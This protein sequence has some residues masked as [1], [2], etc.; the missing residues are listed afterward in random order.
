MRKH[1]PFLE[2]LRLLAFVALPCTAVAQGGAPMLTDDTGTPG[3]KHW[4]ITLACTN[5]QTHAGARHGEIP[6]LDISYGIGDRLEVGYSVAWLV[7]NEAGERSRAG[8]GDSLLGFKWHFFEDPAS[9]LAIAVTPQVEFRNM[10]SSERRGIVD[11]GTTLVLP[12]EI[13]GK[14]GSLEWNAEVGRSFPEI[15]EDAWLYGV[16][17]GRQINPRLELAVELHGTGRFAHKDD[18]LILN[19]GARWTLSEH[20]TLLTALGR[21]LNRVRGEEL[22]YTGYLGLQWT[23]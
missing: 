3:D 19:L 23:Y 18:E 13:Q 12:F 2:I 22:S 11:G 8:L 6:R 20:Q 17:I 9:G 7:V 10:S 21:S 4:E 14:L 5:Q 15:G 1:L 16:A